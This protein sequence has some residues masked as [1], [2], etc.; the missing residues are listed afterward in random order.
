MIFNNRNFV[1]VKRNR[2][3]LLHFVAFYNNLIM[4]Q[5]SFGVGAGVSRH[6][7]GS[8]KMVQLL[9]APAPPHCNIE[10]IKKREKFQF[11]AV[12]WIRTFCTYDPD[13]N[14]TNQEV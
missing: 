1:D 9:V 2:K 7:S 14:P 12:L 5:N 13:P 8:T 10:L 4:L 6:A 11:P 3:K